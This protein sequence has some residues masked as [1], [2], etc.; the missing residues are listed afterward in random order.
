MPAWAARTESSEKAKARIIASV[1]ACV[2]LS[3]RKP[4][5]F[6]ARW[7]G[8]VELRA[9]LVVVVPTLPAGAFARDLTLADAQA[10]LV[11]SNDKRALRLD[12]AGRLQRAARGRRSP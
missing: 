8:G 12:A 9:F 2:N 5:E 7:E 4:L 11:R 6:A 3:L 10:L 1:L